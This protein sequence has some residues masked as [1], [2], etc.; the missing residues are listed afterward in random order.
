MELRPSACQK[1]MIGIAGHVGVGHAF[2][3][4]GFFQ[5]D[6]GGFAV[7]LTLLGRACPLDIEIA[8]VEVL[9]GEHVVVTTRGGGTGS[10][11]ALHGFTPYEERLMQRAVRQRC[12]KRSS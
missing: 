7:L 10:A 9:D 12:I 3:H 1:G 2:S 11:W 5:E 8:S 4:S 6:S